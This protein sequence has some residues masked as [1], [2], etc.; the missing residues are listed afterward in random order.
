MISLHPLKTEP[1]RRLTREEVLEALRLSIIAE[2]DAI[3]LYLQLARA[4]EDEGA[5]RV[6][7]D[8]AREEKTHVGELL[9][10]LKRLD[11]EQEEELRKGAGE[12]A[13]LLGKQ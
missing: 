12:V 7:R 2:L 9:E 10:L 11:H 3:N 13:G 6:L 5:K 8:I 1:S 4:L